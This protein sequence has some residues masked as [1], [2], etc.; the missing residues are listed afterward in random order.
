[1]AQVRDMLSSAGVLETTDIQVDGGITPE[2]AHLAV[3][4]G[5]NVLVAGSAVFR[6]QDIEKAVSAFK[7][8]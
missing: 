5:A 4:E 7:S 8:L 6:A 1:M 3:S 2:N